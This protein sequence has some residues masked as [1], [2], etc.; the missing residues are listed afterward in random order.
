M[1]YSLWLAMR[2]PEV[3][4]DACDEHV[5]LETNFVYTRR[6]KRNRQSDHAHQRRRGLSRMAKCELWPQ[7]A[8]Q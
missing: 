8:Q 3:E 2:Y 7:T 6:R 1:R 4:I 5:S